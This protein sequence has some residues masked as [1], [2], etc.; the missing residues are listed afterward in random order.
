MVSVLILNILKENIGRRVGFF[1]QHDFYFEGIILAV[2]DQ[3]LQYNDR[4]KGIRVISL[5]EIKEVT[6]K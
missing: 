6:L 3:F 5:D 2:D 4:I 1:S